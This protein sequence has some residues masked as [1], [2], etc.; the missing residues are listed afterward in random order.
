MTEYDPAH[1]DSVAATR[2]LSADDA[3]TH[4]HRR[5]QLMILE[6]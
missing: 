5:R 1:F 3:R 2:G 4:K 6:D